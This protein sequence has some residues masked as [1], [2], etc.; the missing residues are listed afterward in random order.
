MSTPGTRFTPIDKTTGQGM[1]DNIWK[2]KG[3]AISTPFKPA[4]KDLFN[5]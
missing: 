4:G 2:N 3:G 5:V 1:K